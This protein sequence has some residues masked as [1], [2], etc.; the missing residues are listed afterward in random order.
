LVVDRPVEEDVDSE[1]KP[2]EAE[3]ESDETLLLVVDRP[4]DEDVESELMPDDAEVD[5]EPT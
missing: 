4:V 3:V 5:S 1:L 2:D